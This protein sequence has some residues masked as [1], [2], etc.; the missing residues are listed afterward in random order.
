VSHTV[1]LP[2]TALVVESDYSERRPLLTAFVGV[3]SKQS[4]SAT[5]TKTGPA[6]SSSRRAAH[7][8]ATTAASSS[9]RARSKPTC[10]AEGSSEGAASAPLLSAP[11]RSALSKSLP[12]NAFR[13]H[14]VQGQC[15][16]LFGPTAL[17]TERLR[18]V[19]GEV[20][21]LCLSLN[22]FR[23]HSTTLRGIP[24]AE[25]FWHTVTYVER[26]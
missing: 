21:V 6:S 1:H 2:P 24:E 16:L 25:A 11:A 10:T 20:K 7:A 14:G 23:C 9:R 26:G 8:V 13:S 18:C 22:V 4:F 17:R 19:C 15:S 12:P 3:R 5:A